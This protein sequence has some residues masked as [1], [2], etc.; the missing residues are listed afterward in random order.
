M[1][2]EYLMDACAWTVIRKLKTHR[3]TII[4]IVNKGNKM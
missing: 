4:K 2:A 1:E 3:Q